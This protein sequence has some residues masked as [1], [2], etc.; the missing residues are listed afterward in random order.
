[1]TI[2]VSMDEFMKI[3]REQVE[4]VAQHFDELV[5]K[6]G[7][8]AAEEHLEQG[9]AESHAMAELAYKLE[10]NIPFKDMLVHAAWD[11]ALLWL[12]VRDGLKT[13]QEVEA[14]ANADI[15]DDVVKKWLNNVTGHP[16]NG[17]DSIN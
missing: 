7:Q 9:I 1:M 8:V 15:T 14:E 2:E 13:V 6:E 10:A 12:D 11:V 17:S 3:I 5:A 16:A 4:F